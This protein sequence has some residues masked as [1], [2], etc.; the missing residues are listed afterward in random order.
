MEQ[1]T[2]PARLIFALK[3][4]GIHFV[5]SCA[6]ALAAALV[7]FA[8][9]IPESY[10]G[11]VCAPQLFLVL[12]AVDVVCGPLLTA[13]LVNP[14]KSRRELW[15][16]FSLVV[17]L[18]LGALA[19]GLHAIANVRPVAMVFEVDRF[20]AVS[21]SQINT[22]DLAQAPADFQQLPWN[23]PQLMGVRA[24]RN[25]A[26]T[27]QSME[28]SFQG[29]EPSVRPGWWQSYEIS[30]PQVMQRMQPIAAL[31]QQASAEQRQVID[32]AMRALPQPLEQVFYLPLVSGSQLDSWIV[33]LDT[34]A[35]IVGHAP[36]GGF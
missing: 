15:L 34:Q 7:V 18:Q 10:W 8:Y 2:K 6:L 17:L 32:E 33:L 14:A 21:A 24:S 23:G 16:D 1:S 30:R 28:L 13:I 26:E 19:Y 22:E 20:V 4:L 35:N 3:A 11:L 25:G 5:A 9:W 36:V 31:H 12:L 29:I 27:L